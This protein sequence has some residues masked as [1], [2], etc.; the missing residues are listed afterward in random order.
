MK[1]VATYEDGATAEVALKGAVAVQAVDAASGIV[2]SVTLTGLESVE[3]VHEEGDDAEPEP[4]MEGAVEPGGFTGEV[5]NNT[6]TGGESAGTNVSW[7]STQSEP[8]SDPD[9]NPD[10]EQQA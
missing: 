8:A 1:L 3:L 9:A 2:S 5:E 4:V 10:A 6:L 7:P